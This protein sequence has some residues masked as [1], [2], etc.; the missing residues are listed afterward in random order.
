M[1][2]HHQVPSFDEQSDASFDTFG[3]TTEHS[4]LAD[5][6][7]LQHLNSTTSASSAFAASTVEL[8]PDFTSA[9]VVI[10]PSTAEPASAASALRSIYFIT[11]G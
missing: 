5:L 3:Y 4:R 8:E 7:H 10:A 11:V 1:R 9:F 6:R 2:P